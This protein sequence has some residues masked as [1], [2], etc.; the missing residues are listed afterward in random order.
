[1]RCK[2]M[3]LGSALALAG[4]LAGTLAIAPAFAQTTAPAAQTAPAVE[5][6]ATPTNDTATKV[7]PVAH[8]VRTASSESLSERNTT[9]QLNEQQLA[10]AQSGQNAQTA[11]AQP[12]AMTPA[13]TQGQAATAGQAGGYSS[14]PAAGTT[15]LNASS[16]GNPQSSMSAPSTEAT[17]SAPAP[18]DTNSNVGP[19]QN[20]GS[21]ASA[22]DSNA[23]P[24]MAANTPSAAANLSA[25]SSGSAVPVTQVQ[26]AQ[27][28][29][30]A[31]KV[32]GAGGKPLGTVQQITSD[33]N[34]APAK[35]QVELDQSLGFGARSVWIN[36]DQLQYLPQNNAVTTTLTPEQ[37]NSM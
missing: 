9:K 6:A 8:H 10:L 28:T 11:Q 30:A 16:A 25:A 33:T 31:A 29:L 32:Q 15:D 3:L 18:G 19:D 4:T 27:Q 17:G 1:M 35:V 21:R 34:G 23:M 36:A 2:N 5:P 12:T 13:P 26:N 20:P 7:A 14:N 22:T 37:L 24:K